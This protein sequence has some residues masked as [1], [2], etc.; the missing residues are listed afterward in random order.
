MIS[1]LE[2]QPCEVRD[3]AGL[4]VGT[5]NV[6]EQEYLLQALE[7]EF[8]AFCVVFADEESGCAAIQHCPNPFSI[9]L[10][11]NPE[12][13]EFDCDRIEYLSMII[14]P[15]RVSMDYGKTAAVANWPKP[16][17]L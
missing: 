16:R 9:D 2:V 5:V 15:S 7:Q 3:H 1:D 8:C 4:I 17:N 11:L 6:M 14:E 10:C 12:K 13:C